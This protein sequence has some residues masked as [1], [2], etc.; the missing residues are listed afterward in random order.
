MFA[1]GKAAFMY[2]G[3][4]A[5]NYIQQSADKNAFEWDIIF[6]PNGPGAKGDLTPARSSGYF[7]PFN[8]KDPEAAWEVLKAWGSL[9][10]VNNLDIGAMTGMP[11]DPVSL[12]AESYNHWPQMMPEHF[13]KD[14]LSQV[15]SRA[16]Y[17]PFYHYYLGE[18]VQN[19]IGGVAD[20]LRDNLDT[21]RTLDAAYN[22]IMANWDTIEYAGKK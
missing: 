11:P 4:W 22:T 12:E 1:D 18:N 3:T 5:T 19:A 9:D 13:S 14:F 17:F 7:I 16:K 10:G 2:A 6:A 21:K 15:A 8:T 20:I